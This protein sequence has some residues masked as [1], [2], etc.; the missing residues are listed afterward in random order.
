[1]E[2]KQ[3]KFKMYKKIKKTYIRTRNRILS[4]L[5]MK[6]NIN[7]KYWKYLHEKD[8]EYKW[9][10][11][12]TTK[13]LRDRKSNNEIE[14]KTAY[15]NAR[16]RYRKAKLPGYTALKWRRRLVKGGW[17]A[18]AGTIAYGAFIAHNPVLIGAG[19]AAGGA[20][21]LG[22]LANFRVEGK[23]GKATREL[24]DQ[25][26]KGY[27]AW[28]KES[29]HAA[30]DVREALQKGTD[31]FNKED[32]EKTF[33]FERFG[34]E[35]QKY[36]DSVPADDR[37]KAEAILY[38]Y[39]KKQ[40]ELDAETLTGYVSNAAD[41]ESARKMGVNFLSQHT[42]SEKFV[43]DRMLPRKD[44]VL[45]LIKDPIIQQKVGAFIEGFEKFKNK[46]ERIFGMK[47]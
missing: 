37:E 3:M 36:L 21:V 7:K 1:M 24:R 46:D 17:A 19:A 38:G 5:G 27:S 23:E 39:G 42:Y 14:R 47:I 44:D 16:F 18:A 10:K 33:M 22:F 41:A 11:Y 31:S 30:S 28:L 15:A 26:F 8:Q 29:A 45:N 32:R 40:S 2:F 43:L 6:T 25:R 35:S 9:D 34:D 4:T 12:D 13:V 20:S